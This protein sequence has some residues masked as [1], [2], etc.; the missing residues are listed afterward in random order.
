MNLNNKILMYTFIIFINTVFASDGIQNQSIDP[1]ND[2]SKP[3][4]SEELADKWLNKIDWKVAKT[5][6][7]ILEK[8]MFFND[9]VEAVTG[10][11]TIHEDNKA[12]LFKLIYPNKLET[13]ETDQP[14]N[15][16]EIVM[17]ILEKEYKGPIPEQISDMVSYFTYYNECIE[18][19]ISIQNRLLLYGEP[20]TGKT[21]LVQALSNALQIPYFSIPA[22]SF[23]DKYIG[24]SS[25]RIRETFS[26][27]NDFNRPV[28]FFIDEIDAIASQ[29]KGS[30]HDESRATL[31]T[32]LVELQDLQKV[33]H[34]FVI[35]ATNDK[36]AL[37][38]A[39][40]NRFSGAICEIKP[41]CKNDKIKLLAKLCKDHNVPNYTGY[42]E[43]LAQVLQADYFCNRDLVSI[44]TTARLKHFVDCEK[45]KTKSQ[46]P[47]HKFFK[48]AIDATGKHAN[49]WWRGTF[50]SGI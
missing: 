31:T 50:G 46:E 49:Y 7:E 19:K 33:P 27:A 42:P 28:I 24:E 20:G 22:A 18:N 3:V 32:L 9:V 11:S 14:I 26:A 25:R 45:D 1:N 47:I 44:V 5:A 36:E 35:V 29:R 38:N 43:A 12:N 6:T 30:T 41:L 17:G 40:L 39:L 2:Q 37:D 16:Y 23:S 8:R 15:K 10:K 13:V 34:V 48:E 21:Y 4:F